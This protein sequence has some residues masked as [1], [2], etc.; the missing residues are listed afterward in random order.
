MIEG[1]A[2]IIEPCW[3]TRRN[4]VLPLGSIGKRRYL[5]VRMR[6]TIKLCI[7]LFDGA[8][9]HAL[10]L[11]ARAADT[12]NNDLFVGNSL[13]FGESIDRFVLELWR[14]NRPAIV[15]TIV[16]HHHHENAARSNP[17]CG[18]FQKKPLHALVLS[19]TDFKVV[20]RVEVQERERFHWSMSI[21]GAALDHFVEDVTRFVCTVRIQFDSISCYRCTLTQ[22]KQRRSSPGTRIED[23]CRVFGELKVVAKSFRF[24]FI[25]WV[26][27]KFQFCLQPHFRIS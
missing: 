16:R 3:R 21:E 7:C 23:A 20:W 15:D 9:I 25:Q 6:Q 17:A 27:A 19:F 14:Q 18:V 13:R 22:S 1:K 11:L 26:V 8:I 4:D 10:P 24:G 12:E 5:F 2:A